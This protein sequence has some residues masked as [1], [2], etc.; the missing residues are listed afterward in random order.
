MGVSGNRQYGSNKPILP[1]DHNCIAVSQTSLVRKMVLKGPI[2]HG[3][4]ENIPELVH[5]TADK[6]LIDYNERLP[7]QCDGE[8]TILAKCDFPLVMEMI[9]NCYN[10]L[11]PK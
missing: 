7:L 1:N 8:T 6:L 3:K 10:V 4:H 2:E 9:P 5:F 11:V